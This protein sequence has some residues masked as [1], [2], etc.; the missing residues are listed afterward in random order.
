MSNAT[1]S[2]RLEVRTHAAPPRPYKWEIFRGA[3]RV[4]V[5]KSEVSFRS[6]DE[7]E[8]SGNAALALWL[9]REVKRED[10]VQG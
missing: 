7:A 4:P 6:K 5:A 3:E 9:T 10:A 1:P 2:F 8:H